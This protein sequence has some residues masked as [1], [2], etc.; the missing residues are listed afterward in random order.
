[1]LNYDRLSRKPLLFRSFTGLELSEFDSIYMEV[2]SKYPDY[3]N[4]EDGELVNK[5][6]AKYPDYKE[7]IDFGEEL[8]KKEINDKVVHEWRRVFFSKY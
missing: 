6:I 3:A 8:K 5:I 2:E 4:I 7:Q 1:M